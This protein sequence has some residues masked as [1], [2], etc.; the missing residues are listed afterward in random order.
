MATRLEQLLEFLTADPHDP[1]N[2]YALAI[3]YRKND[4]EKAKTLFD[5]LLNEF[6]DYVPTYYHAATLY[7][8]NNQEG[9]AIHILQT[10]I[11]VARKQNE[12]KAA[13]ELQGLLDEVV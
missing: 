13:R 11:A 3:E 2:I 6:P 8:E 5:Q 4:I 10:G 12:T 9:E 1:F 7:L